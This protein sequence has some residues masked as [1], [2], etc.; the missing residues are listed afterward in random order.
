MLNTYVYTA[1]KSTC[2][3]HP[4]SGTWSLLPG[5]SLPPFIY[6][7]DLM[8]GTGLIIF[9]KFFNQLISLYIY[10]DQCESF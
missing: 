5:G 6:F 9:C 2:N 4:G 8:G 7:A 3:L 10:Y 1:T